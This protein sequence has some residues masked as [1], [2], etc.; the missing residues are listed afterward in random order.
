[1]R[2]IVVTASTFMGLMFSATIVFSGTIR[3]ETQ[4][5]EAIVGQ[6]IVAG[7]AWVKIS[8][9]GTFSGRSN[10]NEKIRGTWVWSGRYWCRNVVVGTQKWQHDC[11][12]IRTKG[13]T[14][15]FIREKGKGLSNEWIIE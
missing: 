4:F 15:V 6:K 2:K 11:Q 9:N 3:T 8:D 1:M 12:V 14:F 5:R 13:N 7:K 10:S